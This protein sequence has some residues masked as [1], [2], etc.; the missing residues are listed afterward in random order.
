VLVAVVVVHV[1][2]H[3]ISSEGFCRQL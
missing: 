2:S 3:L 1:E